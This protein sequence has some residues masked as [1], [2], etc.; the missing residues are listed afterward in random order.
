MIKYFLFLQLH[1]WLFSPPENLSPDL[2]KTDDTYIIQIVEFDMQTSEFPRFSGL[3]NI[4]SHNARYHFISEYRLLQAFQDDTLNL[5]E[6]NVI[7]E[8]NSYVYAKNKKGEFQALSVNYSTGLNGVLYLDDTGIYNIGNQYFVIRQ[9]KYAYLENLELKYFDNW[10]D[11]LRAYDIEDFRLFL[12]AKELL[13][14]SPEI[15]KFIWKRKFELTDFWQ[16]NIIK[17]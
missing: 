2:Y 4:I 12:F 17:K 6:T 9:L 14:T 16:G 15:E 5:E 10:N 3:S 1:F 13:P 11:E 7:I 8:A